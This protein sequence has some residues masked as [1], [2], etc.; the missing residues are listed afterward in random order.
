MPLLKSYNETLKVSYPASKNGGTM[1]QTVRIDV[2]LK[3]EEFNTSVDHCNQSVNLLTGSIVATE[4]AQVEIIE[5]NSQK[6]AS[7]LVRGIFG[8]IHSEI[9]QQIAELSQSVDAQILFFIKKKLGFGSVT[10]QD[11][12][13]NTHNFRVRDKEGLLQII[14]IFN[15]NFQLKHKQN[16][17]KNFLVA[18]N[19]TYSTEIPLLNNFNL[20]SLNYT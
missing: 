13:S 2:F 17:F 10:K 20:I 6:I 4:A 9:S 18:Y 8:Y 7:S 1:N 5:E 15:G 11:K 16:Q 3:N 12:T 14:N 19:K